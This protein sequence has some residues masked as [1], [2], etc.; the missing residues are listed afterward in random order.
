MACIS[1]VT[2]ELDVTSDTSIFNFF[3]LFKSKMIEA[4]AIENISY[5][6]TT[7]DFRENTS[8]S[9][10]QP[11]VV[12]IAHFNESNLGGQISTASN[13]LINTY[14]SYE[15]YHYLFSIVFDLPLG[16]GSIELDSTDPSFKRVKKASYDPTPVTI[17]YHIY[18]Q[19]LNTVGTDPSTRNNKC[20]F[21]NVSFTVNGIQ[22]M[23]RNAM[24]SVFTSASPAV[25]N[26][27]KYGMKN[28]SYISITDRSCSVAIGQHN[29]GTYTPNT[30]IT[31]LYDRYLILSTLYRHNNTANM[32]GSASESM[33]FNQAAD[34]VGGPFN[35]SNFMLSGIEH[36]GMSV[37]EYTQNSSK[38]PL[39]WPNQVMLTHPNDR[40]TIYRVSDTYIKYN[41]YVTFN[42][43]RDN[44]S[45][46]EYTYMRNN[47]HII[48][49]YL[50]LGNSDKCLSIYTSSP[51]T[52][53]AS[54][55]TYS[56]AFLYEEGVIYTT[57]RNLGT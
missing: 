36:T 35:S 40:G 1:Y 41:P 37:A 32:I 24:G 20:I 51:S 16:D 10:A 4:G 38:S 27:T 49:N 23:N 2:P 50:N 45:I 53:I 12:P 15:K 18:L 9:P 14:A 46:I 26:I 33:K 28:L 55:Y 57:D 7:R 42:K 5:V 25:S 43:K 48:G 22:T 34:V 3:N 8:A 44:I 29:L 39:Y 19:A 56:L 30:A 54:S 11:T 21:V 17:Q 52:L 31:S 13:K 47:T 6:G